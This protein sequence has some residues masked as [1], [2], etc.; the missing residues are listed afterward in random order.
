MVAIDSPSS[1]IAVA[2]GD[3]P[4][5]N[6]LAGDVV[7]RRIDVPVP[8]G[9]ETTNPSVAADGDELLA[10]VR[11][12]NFRVKRGN[13]YPTTDPDGV[14]RTR[15]YLARLDREWNVLDYSPLADDTATGRY[16]F[17]VEGFEDCRL[18]RIGDDRLAAATT[19]DRNPAG[20]CQMALLTV[21]N[22]SLTDL[23][24]LSEWEPRRHEKNWMPFERDGE[25]F[26]L[27]T[28]SRTVVLRYDPERQA[29]ERVA[30]GP[31]SLALAEA[32]GSSQ[33]ARIDGGWLFLVHEN[34]GTFAD[35]RYA[36]CF[37]RLSDDFVVTDASPRFRFQ[38][39]PIEFCAGMALLDD[40][41]YISHG[42]MDR[43]ALSADLPLAAALGLLEPLAD[44]PAPSRIR[45]ADRGEVVYAPV[46]EEVAVSRALRLD[47]GTTPPP[48]F[49]PRA[50]GDPERIVSVTMTG[51][52]RDIIGDAIASVVDWIDA[53]L[54]VD[55]GASD[56]TLG[57][58]Q[59]VAGDKFVE[60][61]YPWRND[62]S[63]A[64]NFALEAAAATGAEW[65]IIL[66]TDERMELDGDALRA[67][68]AETDA[69]IVDMH[70]DSYTYAKQRFFR[71]PAA[72]EFVGPT[73]EAFHTADG[74]TQ[75]RFDG[76]V[77]SETF[78]SDEDYARKSERDVAILQE[79]TALRPHEPRWWYYLGDA[80]QAL[81]QYDE[82]IDAYDRCASLPGWDEEAA[83]AC[84]RSG[85]CF[86]ALGKYQQAI[87][88]CARGMTLHSGL[89]ELPWLA[90]FAA[91]KSGNH[92]KA[93]YWSHVAA[94]LGAYDGV[95]ASV[96][97]Y[98]FKEPAAI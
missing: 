65:A 33:G 66:D 72:G 92:Q 91:Y 32:R 16:D 37:I 35:R 2:S 75:V 62:F 6:R 22:S 78:K 20:I 60:C 61:A 74:H 77:F 69:S 90:G 70:H 30:A 40:R 97:R 55:T 9:W 38:N 53:C 19:R 96:P 94:A 76:G 59:M 17:P 52:A 87:E 3:L 68:L 80:L 81:R 63:A 14:V 21:D 10:I 44:A 13:H 64:R 71:L 11:A 24:L 4:R 42:F 89:P 31:G 47:G 1:P 45:R 86:I 57:V 50:E 83:W 5:L 34:L 48:I 84:F 49:G 93:I 46:E 39:G 54:V 67:L 7:T 58:A 12:V 56:D 8:E 18:I 27:Y 95:T 98:G 43:R 79:E 51:D 25:L 23:V 29:V 15:N 82:A 73:H 28:A 88:V 41:L 26:F 36:H 85:Q